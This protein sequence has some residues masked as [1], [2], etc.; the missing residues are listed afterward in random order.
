VIRSP[1]ASLSSGATRPRGVSTATPMSE[2]AYSMIPS[3]VQTRFACG[4]SR[5]A[6]AT[7]AR[8]KWLTVRRGAVPAS[9]S[10]ARSDIKRPTCA[11]SAR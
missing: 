6:R 7:A 4:M 11:S 5:K 1:A 9:S 8:M 3:S 2:A 10:S